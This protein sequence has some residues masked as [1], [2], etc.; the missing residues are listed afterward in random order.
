MIKRIRIPNSIM[1]YRAEWRGSVIAE[2]S[3][4]AVQLVEGNV[5]FPPAALRTELLR[6]SAA[7]TKSTCGWKGLCS[8]YDVVVDGEVNADAGWF[9]PSAKPAAKNIEGF[10]AFWKGVKVSKA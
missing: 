10:V 5:Y 1:S 8:Y 7:G 4:S 9:Y 6:A 3:E 2:A